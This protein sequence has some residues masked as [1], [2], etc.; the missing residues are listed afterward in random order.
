MIVQ[1]RLLI[2][3]AVLLG[4]HLAW[5]VWSWSRTPRIAY[6]RSE[7]L[8]YGYFGMKEAV[9]AFQAEQQGWRSNL[10]SLTADLRRTMAKAA[11]LRNEGR[12]DEELERVAMKQQQELQRYA[13][14]ME[15][16]AQDE[17]REQLQAVLGQ[18]NTFV[19][20]YAAQHG[21][22]MV[23][24]TTDEGNVL[25]GEG[26]LDIT[27]ELLTALNEHHQGLRP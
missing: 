19:G 26:A 6:V 18:I 23:L 24:G 1:K 2:L 9:D 5:S 25:Y 27:E 3:L 17:E 4:V 11:A 20:A 21:Y 22:N 14:A 15:A 13:K 12:A 16:K 7:E 10:D 8:V